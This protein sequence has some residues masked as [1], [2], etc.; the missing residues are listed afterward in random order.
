MA[1][2]RRVRQLQLGFRQCC[3]N[4]K[5]A[6][7]EVAATLVQTARACAPC[8][9]RRLMQEPP[10]ETPA[11]ARCGGLWVDQTGY[12]VCSMGLNL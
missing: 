1:K 7:H 9:G 5:A 12:Q 10:R 6:A 4:R 11:T 3:S 8:T 2:E